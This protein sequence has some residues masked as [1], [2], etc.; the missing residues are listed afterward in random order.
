[1]RKKRHPERAAL[2]GKIAAEN[3]LEYL[4]GE[5]DELIEPAARTRII[6]LIE[7]FRQLLDTPKEKTAAIAVN[8]QLER[9]PAYPVQGW[10]PYGAIEF[11]HEFRSRRAGRSDEAAV[12]YSVVRMVEF[13]ELDNLRQC[14]CGKWFM[15]RRRKQQSCSGLCRRKRYA[16]SESGRKKRREYAYRRYH[17]L[18]SANA[19]RRQ[20]RAARAISIRPSKTR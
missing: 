13:G 12:A 18:E 2:L 15:A 7:N 11:G 8:R 20:L 3:V 6:R 1:M 5:C 14:I 19:A 17:E 9:Y 16:Q 10:D 4:N